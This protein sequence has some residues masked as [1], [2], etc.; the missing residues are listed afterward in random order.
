M[1]CVSVPYLALIPEMAIGYD[2]RIS[3]NTYRNVAAVL[4]AFAAVGMKEL[5]D[6]FG[7]GAAGVAAAGAVYRRLDRRCRGS[8]S[9]RSASSAR[10]SHGRAQAGLPRG[11]AAAARHRTFRR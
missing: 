8:R 11:R 2:E 9:G 3:L 10:S 4:G 5:A 6:A 7:G 1:T